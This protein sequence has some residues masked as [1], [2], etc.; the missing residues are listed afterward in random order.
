MLSSGAYCYVF[1]YKEPYILWKMPFINIINMKWVILWKSKFF[2]ESKTQEQKCQTNKN[3][4]L[5]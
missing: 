1:T 4:L 3:S 5:F 2:F